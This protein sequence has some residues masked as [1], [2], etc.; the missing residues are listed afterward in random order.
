[1]RVAFVFIA[2]A[3]FPTLL[4]VAALLSLIFS[5]RF[6]LGFYQGRLRS[7]VGSPGCAAACARARAIV[8]HS[9]AIAGFQ[10]RCTLSQEEPCYDFL[11]EVCVFRS[12]LPSPE[13][14]QSLSPTQLISDGAAAPPPSPPCRGPLCGGL[15]EEEEAGAPAEPQTEEREREVEVIPKMPC[16]DIEVDE[17][18]EVRSEPAAV[19][20]EEI[21][22]VDADEKMLAQAPRTPKRTSPA[23][24]A[25]SLS[26]P[27][28]LRTDRAANS[29]PTNS[30]LLNY[31]QQMF[32]RQEQ[33]SVQIGDVY[34][35]VTARLNTHEEDIQKLHCASTSRHRRRRVYDQRVRSL[36]Q[37]W[38]SWSSAASG[39]TRPR[40]RS[41]RSSK[42]SCVQSWRSASTCRRGRPSV[43][44]CSARSAFCGRRHQLWHDKQCP[45]CGTPAASR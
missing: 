36:Q 33:M 35:K 17:V 23:A 31:M 11:C 15:D 34:A 14:E 12:F 19:D 37:R 26:P 24:E 40:R 21:A 6:F 39:R 38:T 1:M 43:R 22:D 4:V 27:K 13:Q 44:T 45:S 7:Q 2:S 9:A 8:D 30:D 25:S 16:D 18:E 42:R 29:E 41:C 32:A 10:R 3:V 5:L 20:I 28:T